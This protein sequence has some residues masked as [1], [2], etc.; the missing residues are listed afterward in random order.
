LSLSQI[1]TEKGRARTIDAG[2]RSQ[3]ALESKFEDRGSR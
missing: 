2:F 1:Q 3:P